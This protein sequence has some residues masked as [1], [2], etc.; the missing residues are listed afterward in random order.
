MM[1]RKHFIR[2]ADAIKENILYDPNNKQEKPKDV[3]LGGLIDSISYMCVC[4][5]SNFD[6]QRFINYI[7]EGSKWWIINIYG[8]L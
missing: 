8:V 7:N 2:L 1:T 4:E 5:N 6:K 3:D